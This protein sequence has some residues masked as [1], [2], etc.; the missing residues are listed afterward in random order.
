M[1]PPLTPNEALDE[2]F[3]DF[4]ETTNFVLCGCSVFS[5]SSVFSPT[6]SSRDSNGYGASPA[7][8]LLALANDGVG[9]GCHEKL[10]QGDA[11]AAS[12]ARALFQRDCGPRGS[13]TERV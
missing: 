7:R 4:N 8:R 1:L 2:D 3:E 9:E 10:S 5:S 13:A 11:G 6:S 12:H